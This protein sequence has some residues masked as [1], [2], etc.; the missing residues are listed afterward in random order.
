MTLDIVQFPCLQDN[1]GYLIRDTES[2]LVAAIDTP[3]AEAINHQLEERGWKLS[4]ILNTH[5]HFDHTGGNEALKTKW[6]CTIVGPKGEA[7]RIPGI[8]L[9][10]DDGDE[11]ALGA[12]TARILATPGHTLGHIVYYFGDARVAFVGDTLFALGCGRL[13]EGSADQM[14]TSLS[15]LKA[16][17]P[18]TTVYCAHEYTQ[19]NARFALSIEPENTIL[20]NRSREIDQYRMENKPTVPTTIAEELRTNPFLRADDDGLQKAIGMVGEPPVDV[21]AEIR[22]RKDQF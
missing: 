15:K 22:S 10:L 9:L 4:Y 1:Y 2:G 16:L 7:N 12:S 3:D 18:E 13:F 17:P 6:S 11:F 20:Q 5:H 8:D 21:F 14:W 19:A